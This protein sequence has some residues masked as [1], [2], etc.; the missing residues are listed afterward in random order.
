[1]PG[2]LF[3]RI[4]C[5]FKGNFL[6][7]SADFVLLLFRAAAE[8]KFTLRGIRAQSFFILFAKASEKKNPLFA[9]TLSGSHFVARLLVVFFFFFHWSLGTLSLGQK[10]FLLQR[11][12]SPRGSEKVMRA[13]SEY[14]DL[15]RGFRR[16]KVAK[17]GRHDGP[18][19]QDLASQKI[20]DRT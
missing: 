4:G 10:S 14:V 18:T 17:E 6:R 20:C 8:M 16:I 5:T 2:I 1:M 19:L 12:S 9:A 3:P 15:G 7:R 11:L 13:S